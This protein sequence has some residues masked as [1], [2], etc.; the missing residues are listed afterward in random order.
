VK[1]REWKR[2]ERE[3]RRK[4]EEIRKLKEEI[5]ALFVDKGEIREHPVAFDIVDVNGHFERNRPF[6]GSLGGQ[7]LQLCFALN[8]L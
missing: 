8:G 6:F 5:K 7:L 4:E 2:E 1:R 3:R